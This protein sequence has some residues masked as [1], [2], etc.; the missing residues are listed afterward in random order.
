M[1]Y[2]I[3]NLFPTPI[4]CTVI[5]E[6][7]KIQ[8]EIGNAISTSQFNGSEENWGKSVDVTDITEDIIKE[9][10]IVSLSECIDVHLQNYCTQLQFQFKEYVRNSWLTKTEKNNHTHVH[11]HSYTDISGCYYY[12]TN[13]EDGNIFFI[14]PTPASSAYCFQKYAERWEHK[15]LVGKLILF[16]SYLLHGVKTNITNSVRISLS[17]SITFKR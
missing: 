15:P 5:N 14:T 8:S 16:P 13:T 7:D 6:I 9:K 11:D 12:Q 2:L 17:F 3:E 4:Y 1:T 10:N